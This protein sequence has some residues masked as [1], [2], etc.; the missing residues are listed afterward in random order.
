MICDE[1]IP[2]PGPYCPV[3]VE[4]KNG[5]KLSYTAKVA[6]GDPRNPMSEDE[7]TEKF[8]GNARLAI[9]EKQA[10]ALISAVKQLES[11]EKVKSHRRA[12]DG[13]K[14]SADIP[15]R[16]PSSRVRKPALPCVEP[17][18]SNTSLLHHSNLHWTS[19][20]LCDKQVLNPLFRRPPCPA[21]NL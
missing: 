20:F 14:R 4:L 10:E 16:V 18:Y 7:V 8:R 21:T 1:S 5:T 15:V 9:A 13:I 11:V 2:E 12:A 3:S 19:I 17:N 6:K